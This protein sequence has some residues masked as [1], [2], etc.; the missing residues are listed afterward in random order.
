MKISGIISLKDGVS[1][2]YPFLEAIL[3]VLPICDEFLINDG[4]SR[5]ATGKWL[6]RLKRTFPKIRL[7]HQPWFRSPAWEALDTTL[8]YLIK[9]AK[10]DWLLEVQGDELWHEKTLLRVCA[11]VRQAQRRGYNSLR[12][13]RRDCSFSRLDGHVYYVVRFVRNLDNLRSHWGGDDFQLGSH[14]SPKKGHSSHN[15]PPERASRFPFYHLHRTFPDSTLRQ[16]KICFHYLAYKTADR[17]R[18]L[19]EGKKVN[20]RQYSLTP[21]GKVLQALPA[22]V[23]GLSQQRKYQVREELFDKKWLR[24]TTGLKY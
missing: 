12:N 4:G 2:G 13:R 6:R 9:K 5:D 3:S 17:K 10:G 8:E 16:D 22:L 18:V 24:Q 7:F 20:W 11:E 19:K 1:T 14:T 21:P 23:K 15:V